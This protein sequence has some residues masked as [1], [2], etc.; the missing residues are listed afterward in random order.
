[1]LVAWLQFLVIAALIAASGFWLVR[2]GHVI[3]VKTGLGGTWIGVILVATVTSLPELI[4]GISSVTVA[5]APDIA[6]GDVLGS[7]VFNLL[8]IAVLDFLH[9]ES[10]IYLR[11]SQGH[12]L[13][14]GFSIILIG[15]ATF[16]LLA[17]DPATLRLWHIGIYTPVIII[18][19]LVAVRAIYIHERKLVDRPSE[20]AT[21]YPGITLR[22]AVLRYAAA[23][24]LVV[25]AGVALP[26]AAVRLAAAMGWG[27]SFVGTL[28][29][30][31]ATSLPEAASTIGA[32]KLR[33]IDLAIGNLFGSNLFNI[34]ILAIDDMA[35]TKGPLLW[36]ISP[37]H[38][39]SGISAMIMTGAAIVGLFYRP[40]GRVFKI[41]GWVSLA[42]VLTY[43]LNALV[44]YLRAH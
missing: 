23:A 30:A 37:S 16:S 12:I 13:S 10:A 4:T 19:Y 7:C 31:G 5:D 17:A 9:R 33:A 32:L 27:Q 11:A 39:V 42:I 1:V 44:L 41:A 34:L 20:T 14:A 22:Q 6:V 29:V 3:A 25:V 8:L 21:G 15:L 18:L 2:Y 24:A 43:V 35:Y 26:F 40:A 38:A 36:S 28:L